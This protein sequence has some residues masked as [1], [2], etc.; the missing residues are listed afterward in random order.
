MVFGL[1]LNVMFLIM[2]FGFWL[3]IIV[4][5]VVV[6]LLVFLM[7]L[8]VGRCIWEFGI[9]KVIGWLNGCVVW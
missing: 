8:G 2:N 9:F 7:F 6:L 1:L 5:V 3:L 4:F